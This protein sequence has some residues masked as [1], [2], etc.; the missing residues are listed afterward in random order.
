MVKLLRFFCLV[1]V[2][3]S[4]FTI[5]NV[6]AAD[7]MDIA[8]VNGEKLS[9]DLDSITFTSPILFKVWTYHYYDEKASKV[10][11]EMYGIK[12][13]YLSEQECWFNITK[14]ENN[15]LN[16]IDYDKSGKV[17]NRDKTGIG[18]AKFGENS[19]Y[20][21]VFKKLLPIIKVPVLNLR[22]DNWIKI[23]SDYGIDY[24]FYKGSIKYIQK[25]AYSA[26]IL[27]INSDKAIEESMRTAG[28]PLF[29]YVES[30]YC[31]ETYYILTS[32]KE[33]YFYDDDLSFVSS[34]KVHEY[35]WK[36]VVSGTIMG[37]IYKK[38]NE[39]YLESI[40]SGKG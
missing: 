30:I 20:D 13:L 22:D 11:E 9:V 2:F 7:W 40:R 18:W 32:L 4:Y 14:K 33:I 12:D 15:V 39:Y 8:E 36:G 29:R 21:L 23:F 28:F 27:A 24:Y 31:F 35:N 19:E 25:G 6:R 1:L 16:T 34:E 38:V 3:F 37:E 5:S 26:R 10:M 17:I